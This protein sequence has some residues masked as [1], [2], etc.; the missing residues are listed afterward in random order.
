MD[1]GSACRG[2]SPARLASESWFEKRRELGRIFLAN[3]ECL[4]TPVAAKSTHRSKAASKESQTSKGLLTPFL[5]AFKLEWVTK[6]YND[7]AA[8]L[9][10]VG[11]DIARDV[12]GRSGRRMTSHSAF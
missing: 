4:A 8:A 11:A 2:R 7:N 1:T 10:L 12:A 5:L 3:T 9:A 6:Y